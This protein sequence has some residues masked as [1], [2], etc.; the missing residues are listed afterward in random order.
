[1][2]EGASCEICGATEKLK[3]DHDHKTGKIRGVLCNHHNTGLGMFQDNPVFLQ[4]AIN[5]LAR[6]A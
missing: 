4:E 5:Y 2:K 6:T 1:M 3:I